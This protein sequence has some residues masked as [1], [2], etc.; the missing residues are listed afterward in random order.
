MYGKG[1]KIRT[2]PL[3][4]DIARAIRQ[5]PTGYVFPGLDNGHLSPAWVGR[6]M[7]DALPEAWTA[8]TLR[9]R[10]ATRAYAGSRDLLAVQEL[11]GH[12][13]PDTTKRYVEIPDAAMRAALGFAA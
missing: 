9:H 12:A 8:H 3:G 11:L 2:I 6:L 7:S 4:D 5:H 13:H 10:F 1:R